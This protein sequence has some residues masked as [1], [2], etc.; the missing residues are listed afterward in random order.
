MELNG[1]NGSLKPPS[2]RNSD[3]DYNNYV[4]YYS[5]V[6]KYLLSNHNFIILTLKSLDRNN[7][8]I[9]EPKNIF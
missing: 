4:P 3:S 6:I 8:L 1:D 7:I 9:Q 2:L 5:Y